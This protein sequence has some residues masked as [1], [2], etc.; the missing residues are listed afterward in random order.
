[1]RRRFY[2]KKSEEGRPYYEEAT[3]MAAAQ[4]QPNDKGA[5]VGFLLRMLF[6][7]PVRERFYLDNP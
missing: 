7:Q 1:L 3:K 4:G 6:Y 5:V 2:W